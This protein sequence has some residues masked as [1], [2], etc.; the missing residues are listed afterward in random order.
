MNKRDAQRLNDVALNILDLVHCMHTGAANEITQQ[1]WQDMFASGKADDTARKQW[2]RWKKDL[3]EHGMGSAS[4][5][6]MVGRTTS[7]SSG[8]RSRS[9]RHC[10]SRPR[11]C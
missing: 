8:R 6:P 5:S 7:S 11:R 1:A 2:Q 3:E 10:T 9:P 4:T